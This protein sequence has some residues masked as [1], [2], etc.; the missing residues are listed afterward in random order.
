ME[1]VRKMWK[2]PN[3]IAIVPFLQ[4]LPVTARRLQTRELLRDYLAIAL[5]LMEQTTGSIHGI[6]QTFQPG[7]R[8]FSNT[9]RCCSASFPWQG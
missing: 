2:S 5:E 1:F 6:H 7:C 8:N 4:S 9:F 3:S